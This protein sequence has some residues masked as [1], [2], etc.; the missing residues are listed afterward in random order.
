[1][2]IKIVIKIFKIQF[3]RKFNNNVTK[4]MKQKNKINTIINNKLIKMIQ[5]NLLITKSYKIK[6]T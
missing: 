5:N 1:M 2:K 6:L 4:K 3:K